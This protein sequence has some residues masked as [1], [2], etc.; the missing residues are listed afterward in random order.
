MLLFSNRSRK[1]SIWVVYPYLRPK[2]QSF[3]P[4]RKKHNEWMIPLEE[5]SIP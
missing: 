2:D 3:T 4:M 1:Y 5:A